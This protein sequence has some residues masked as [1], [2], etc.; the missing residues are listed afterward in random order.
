MSIKWEDII[1]GFERISFDTYNSRWED[2][3]I[4]LANDGNHC[5]INKKDDK[6]TIVTEFKLSNNPRINIYCSWNFY[7]NNASQK[8]IARPTIYKLKNDGTFQTYNSEKEKINIS[9]KDGIIASKFWDMISFIQGFNNLIDL[10]IFEDKYKVISKDQI[11]STLNK[12]D[13]TQQIQT[14]QE[15]VKD[16]DISYNMLER[17]LDSSK[18]KS[19]DKF[20]KMLNLDSTTE[21]EWQKFFEENP[22]IFAGV[23]LKLFFHRDIIPQSDI[24]ITDTRG[25]GAPISDLLCID[26]YTTLVELKKH[27]TPIFTNTRHSTSRTNT[28]SF[29]PEFIDGISQCLAQKQALLENQNSKTIVTRTNKI[30]R[31]ETQDPKVIYIIGNYNKE[32]INPDNDIEDRIKANTFERYRRDCRNIEIITYDELYERACYI[33]FK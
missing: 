1:K 12:Y 20:K 30:L 21:S 10:G 25:K 3:E 9:L 22:W 32:I 15:F 4:S 18:E 31:I 23:S 28:W 17:L 14:I 16:K 13:T 2:I 5:Y 24:G 11:L 27:T 33:V 7:K 26:K 8:F 29:S 19:L 6:K